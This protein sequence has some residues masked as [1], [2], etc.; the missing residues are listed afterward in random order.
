MDPDLPLP[1][2]VYRKICTLAGRQPLLPDGPELESS[3]PIGFR[4]DLVTHSLQELELT[5]PGSY[6]YEWEGSEDGGGTNLWCD[7]AIESPIWR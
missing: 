3:F 6:Q 4:R 1:R 2:D 7:D 5:I